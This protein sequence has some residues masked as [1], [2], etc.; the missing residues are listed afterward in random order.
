MAKEPIVRAADTVRKQEVAAGAAT[1]VQVLLGPED[2]APNFAMRRFSMGREGGMPLHK[3]EV[4]HEQYVL[5][6]RARVGIGD[7]VFEVQADDVLF[8]PA[9]VPHF[10]KVLEEPFEFLC[11]VPNRP[12]QIQILEE[13]C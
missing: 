2:G 7:R 1:R 11:I 8:I 6:G 12:D 10:Y 5:K 4:E 3:N 9:G 13:G